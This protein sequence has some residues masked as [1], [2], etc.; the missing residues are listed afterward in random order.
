MINLFS[1]GK[2]AGAQVP[3]QDVLVV[4]VSALTMD[5]ALVMTTAVYRSA[6]HM[7]RQKYQMR[8]LTA[9]EGG[10]SFSRCRCDVKEMLFLL[11]KTQVISLATR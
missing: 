2:H 11:F 8:L 9:D 5:Q 7:C 1:G 3:I 4:P 10:A 6:A